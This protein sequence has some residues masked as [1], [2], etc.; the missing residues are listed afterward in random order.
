MHIG[1]YW[2]VDCRQKR[3]SL[4]HRDFWILHHLQVRPLHWLF[5]LHCWESL[6]LL[7][8]SSP[9]YAPVGSL[10]HH[11]II[12]CSPPPPAAFVHLH[13]WLVAKAEFLLR[14][15]NHL[16]R[17][18]LLLGILKWWSSFHV[19]GKKLSSK[20][21]QIVIS[22]DKLYSLVEMIIPKILSVKNDKCRVWT[23]WL[24]SR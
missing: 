7:W 19:H 2:L 14:L 6:V 13:F 20:I 24:L 5:Y 17:A 8:I 16:N 1:Q 15:L 10:N 11:L 3:T 23:C 12:L 22:V 21:S 9:M 4:S 18:A